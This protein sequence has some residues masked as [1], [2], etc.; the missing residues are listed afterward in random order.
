[1]S[2]VDLALKASR[3]LKRVLVAGVGNVLRSDDGFGVEVARRLFKMDLPD[4]VKVV[5]TGIAGMALVQELYQDVD[6][7]I[8]VDAVDRG[9][10][11]GTVMIIEPDV[12]DAHL[13]S[14]LD[15]Y[16]M[17][18]DVHLA[19]PER[20]FVMAKAL[21]VLPRKVLVVGCQPMDA[22]TMKQGMSEV[23]V[24]AIGP[25]IREVLA[26]LSEYCD[27]AQRD[28]E[29]VGKIGPGNGD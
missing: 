21:G 17:L 14:P 2:P 28:S 6:L 11:P 27:D 12:I 26:L 23:V 1:M 13:L 20:V 25:A 18:A 4:W 5:E 9:R 10:I 16:D 7:L 3:P 24:A 8:V 19:T 29:R 15:R 22:D